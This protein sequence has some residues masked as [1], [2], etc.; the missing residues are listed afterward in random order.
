VLDEPVVHTYFA[1]L[2]DLEDTISRR[3]CDLDN[4]DLR[5]GTNFH[6]WPK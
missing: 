4:R 1:T 5:T 2:A 6:W 3:C